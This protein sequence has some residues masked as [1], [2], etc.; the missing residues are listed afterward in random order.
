[1]SAHTLLIVD[2]EPA[3]LALLTQVLQPHYRVRAANS[4]A[5]A[6]QAA[7][8]PPHP[9]LILLDVMMPDMDGYAVL[10]RLRE[11]PDTR[12]IPVIFVTALDD[13]V[14]EEHGLESGAVDYIA[15][16]VK[17]AI[18]MARVRSQLEL[19]Q[20][21]DRLADQNSW[22]EAEVARRTEEILTIQDVGIHALAQLAETRDPETG[23]HIRRTQEY[24]N[25][26]AQR[27]RRHPRFQA[28][29]DD[30]YIQVLSKSAPLHDIG[31]VG[32]PDTILL[33]P[34]R[35]DAAEMAIMRRHAQ[36]G[37]DAI[38]KALRSSG[39]PADFLNV[40][41]EIARWHHERWDGGGY[42]DGLAG[43]AIPVSARL[44][45][46]ADVFDALVSPR[47]YKDAMSLDAARE[48]IARGRGGHFDPDVAEAFLTDFDAFAAIAGRFRDTG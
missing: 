42:P 19:K 37:A 25:L 12:A 16:P 39:R 36:L 15:K 2:D 8:T 30:H 7:V 41:M 13:D 26:L 27:L 44:M 43:E 4:G 10:T 1:M 9:D 5:R 46:I 3:N 33:K 20:A 28:T 38:A 24:V 18:V 32:I 17:A 47:V 45:A 6:L 29:L 31:K 22:L 34:G 48:I 23:N 35:L 14:N 11:N 21:R 40:A